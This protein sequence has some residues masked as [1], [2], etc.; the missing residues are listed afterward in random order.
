MGKKF[1]SS[2]LAIVMTAGFIPQAVFAETDS[3][4]IYEPSRILAGTTLKIQGI[5][6]FDEYEYQWMMSDSADGEYTNIL[7]D[8][9][10]N[11]IVTPRDKGKYFKV[12]VTNK[13]T[14]EA[15]L[16]DNCIFVETLGP[17]SKT[18]FRN[19]DANMLTPAENK[20]SVGGQEFILLDEFDDSD[21]A[22]YVMTE[23]T[24]GTIAFDTNRYAKFDTQAEGNI[25]KFLNG[26]FLANGNG[27]KVLPT[28]I[29]EHINAGH[30]WYTEGGM[31]RAKDS[32]NSL[33]C[34]EDYSFAAGVS[35][36]SQSEA[37]KYHGKYGWQPGGENATTP[38]W[39]RTQRGASGTD[40]N[41]LVMM[42]SDDSDKGN[43]IDKLCTE[44]YHIR[45]T[46]YLDKD[47]FSEEKL[48]LSSTGSNIKKMITKK[49]TA[50]QME[51][52]YSVEELVLLGYGVKS[53]SISKEEV[54]N[55]GL[56]ALVAK[57][58]DDEAVDYRY[59]WYI[60]DSEDGELTEVYGN[61]TNK[62]IMAVNDR[63][64]YITA[65]VIPV[66]ADG[67]MGAEVRSASKTY[68]ENIGALGRTNYSTDERVPYKNNP[69]EYIFTAGGEKM[70]LL[71]AFS[72]EKNALY[73]MTADAKGSYIFDSDKTQKFDVEDLNNIGYWLNNEFKTANQT[74]SD[75]VQPYINTE[76]LWWTEAGNNMGN[77][78]EDYS[79]VAGISLLSRSEYS[80]YWGKFGWD[81]NDSI[82]T[83]WWLRTGRNTGVG[84][85]FCATGI[86]DGNYSNLS[87]NGYA[88]TW[89]KNANTSY[90]VRPTFYLTKD[91]L[92]NVKITDMGEKAAEGIRKVLTV[93]EFM[94]G[95]AGYTENELIKLGI[96]ELPKAENVRI[97]GKASV[98][99]E[100]N[101]SYSYVNG[102]IESGTV[103]GFEMSDSPDGQFK[104]FADGAVCKLTS[105]QNKKYIRFFV[106]PCNEDGVTGETYY[107]DAVIV[108][109]N[110]SVSAESV[111]VTD[112]A[113]NIA[114]SLSRATKLKVTAELVNYSS[115]DK[116]AWIMVFVYDKD[117]KMIDNRGVKVNVPSEGRVINNKL[118]INLPEYAEGN[119]AKVIIWDGLLTMNSAQNTA[120]S[121]Q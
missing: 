34:P 93:E 42:G 41:I 84:D 91:F 47:F 76:H 2:L 77:C 102:K 80:K 3:I 106:T 83:A 98:G 119:Y 28:E 26:D 113:G 38:W 16:S 27:G 7:T 82:K 75:K 73:V 22:Y 32:S 36:L 13:E 19:V 18:A 81:D 78:P 8:T 51:N 66:Y 100:L 45:P 10:E 69:K 114:T 35:L 11:Y 30:V 15:T 61:T 95:N 79:F 33:D 92:K 105:A 99:A 70:I 96:I 1:Y 103:S 40:D 74:I 121:I 68:V 108:L 57:M 60:S 39:G 90:F 31:T 87:A 20:F 54:P 5:T 25:G 117:N 88:N 12:K 110:A 112:E 37:S 4:H 21:S 115:A 116:N 50:S 120:F 97:S 58:N 85:V 24:Y 14:D 107:S 67:S 9:S 63:T 101:G 64:K 53:I 86:Q 71:D 48:D 118:S 43:M 55:S 29:R 111:K 89:N 44:S 23:G 52:I 17:I 56:W 59:K 49:Y 109:G 72:D 65:G 6:N 94:A 62:Y 104:K 46:F